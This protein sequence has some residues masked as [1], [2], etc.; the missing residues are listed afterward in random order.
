M[1]RCAAIRHRA[2]LSA[3]DLNL[4]RVR[5]IETRLL[6]RQENG[7]AALAYVWDEG[8][9]ARRVYLVQAATVAGFDTAW[10]S[11]AT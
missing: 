11:I 10:R 5:L 8:I 2:I 7:C 3:K 4:T 1:S 6:V 9:A